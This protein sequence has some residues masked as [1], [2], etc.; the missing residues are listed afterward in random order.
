MI[1]QEGLFLPDLLKSKLSTRHSLALKQIKLTAVQ[2]GQHNELGS[3][4]SDDS[5]TRKDLPQFLG[6][7]PEFRPTQFPGF[8]FIKRVLDVLVRYNFMFWRIVAVLVVLGFEL[9]ASHLLTR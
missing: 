8:S 5:L 6:D 9:S 1:H 3:Q 7:L 4:D 2:P